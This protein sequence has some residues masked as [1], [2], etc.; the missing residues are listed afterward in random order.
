[1]QYN[2]AL[3]FLEYYSDPSKISTLKTSNRGNVLKALI[4]LSKFLGSYDNFTKSIK[5]NGIHW[6]SRNG[7]DSFLKIVNGN[8]K[9]VIEWYKKTQTVLPDNEKLFVRFVLLSGLRMSE[10][11]RSFSKIIELA[12][13][14]RLNEYYDDKQQILKHYQYSENLRHTK[15]VYISIVS[16]ELI[17]EIV[18]SKAVSYNVIRKHLAKNRM[19]LELKP[20][21]S[22]FATY[23]RNKGIMSEIID[24]IQGRINSG[25]VFLNHYL[26]MDMTNL[27]DQIL[28]ILRD[29]LTSVS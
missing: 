7:F 26:K 22:L 12:K 21:R 27:S 8:H 10:A 17:N 6:A 13:Q 11:K 16:R 29:L 3:R 28:P 19:N 25:S 23:L 4:S 5:N 15:N 1:M 24:L 18:N 14:N 2:T 20:L 9:D